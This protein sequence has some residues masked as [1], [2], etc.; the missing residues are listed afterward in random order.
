MPD[1]HANTAPRRPAGDV[2][3]ANTL[4]RLPM[5]AFG[6][7]ITKPDVFRRCAEPG[8]RRAAEADSV[9]LDRPACGTLFESYNALLDEAAGLDDLEALVLV[10]QDAEIDD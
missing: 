5:I 6:T 7:A 3:T 8:I 2:G 9:V 4:A 1:P 10:H